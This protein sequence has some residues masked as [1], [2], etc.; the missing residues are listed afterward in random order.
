MPEGFA[1]ISFD[2]DIWIPST[3][4]TL[5]SAPAIVQDRGSRQFLALGR[6]KDGVA[7]ARAQE[8]LTRVATILEQ[9]FPATNRERGVDLALLHASLLGGTASQVTSLFGAVLL[10]LA[11]A[12]ANAAG[13]Q[14]V[15]ALSRRRELAL[16]L[17]L[18]ARRSHVL[19]QLLVESSLLSLTAG[20]I[21]AIGAAAATNLTVALTPAGALPAHV[22]P[23]I[24][25]RTLAFTFGV[26]L[27]V[28]LVVALVASAAALRANVSDVLKQGGRAVEGGLGAIR[29]PSLQQI[30]VAVEIA[31]AMVLLTLAGL[32][33]RSLDRQA[34]VR[35]GLE[36]A[37]VTVARLT[38]PTARYPPA[39]RADF[40]ERLDRE[41]RG[42]PRVQSVA[43]A[44][45]LPLTGVSSAGIMLPDVAATPDGALRYYRHVVTP[46]F[47][48]TFGI[49]I[50]AGRAFT[51]LD[52]RGAP[53]VAIVNQDAARRIWGD[54]DPIG[55]RFR[56][57]RSTDAAPIEV[58]GIS[59]TV[60]YRDLTTDLAAAGAEPD[61]YF[62]YG[63][64]TSN[65][66]QIAVKT[67]DGEVVP[68]GALQRAVAQIDGGVP[69]YQVRQMADVVRQQTA[70]P[71]FV[72]TLLGVFSAGALL[73][74]AIGLYGLIA[75]VIGLS[76]G[77]IAIRLALGAHRAT[78][79]G[80]VLRNGMAVGATGIALGLV[81]SLIAGRAIQTQLFQTGGADPGTLAMVAGTLIAVT[82]LAS[83]VPTRHAIRVDPQRALRGE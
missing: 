48:S 46:E 61:V 65:D 76:R 64:V 32:V 10:F 56:L 83:V 18:G 9:E 73:L 63:Q 60:R 75:Y 11:V 23:T 33:A 7:P 55:R 17:A 27:L 66:L 49:P 74:A 3:M 20:G 34:Q 80:L 15:R 5:E 47:F 36:P 29:R 6:L 71:R 28:G 51:A 40:V 21:G 30:L 81:G 26:S 45:D 52:R 16:R 2:T 41:L 12:C 35:L 14:L 1:G 53:A 31:A 67:T 54:G 78:I 25:L 82:L 72:S 50:V 43:V 77:E 39:Q 19:R 59:A 44:S 13:L 58:V 57:G 37:G 79:V 68:I 70:A 62:P 22:V 4:V 42:V 8:D 24:D 69:I 38:L